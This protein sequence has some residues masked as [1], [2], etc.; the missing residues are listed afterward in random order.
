MLGYRAFFDQRR[1]FCP[2]ST[3]INHTL[4]CSNHLLHHS[5]AFAVGSPV[6]GRNPSRLPAVCWDKFSSQYIS[7]CGQKHWDKT[8]NIRAHYQAGRSGCNLEAH[9][10]KMFSAVNG[11]QGDVVRDT[12]TRGHSY[13]LQACVA[14]DAANKGH[15]TNV[16]PPVLLAA[17]SG[18]QNGVSGMGR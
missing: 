6:R 5:C 13:H 10:V 8:L 11:Q 9:A 2:P 16:T 15:G 14:L 12:S 1:F 18:I 7:G 3:G 17:P 4:S